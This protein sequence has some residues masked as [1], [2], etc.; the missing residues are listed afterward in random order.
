MHFGFQEMLVVALI[1]LIMFGGKKLP[2]LARGLGQGIRELRNAMHEEL[3]GE[4]KTTT[5]TPDPNARAINEGSNL[6][7]SIIDG[8]NTNKQ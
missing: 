5:V 7:R 2:E 1:I 4:N 3:P 8:N 6:S